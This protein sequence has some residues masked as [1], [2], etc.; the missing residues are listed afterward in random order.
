MT[1]VIDTP[2]VFALMI[3]VSWNARNFCTSAGSAAATS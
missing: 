2:A 3:E 1:R